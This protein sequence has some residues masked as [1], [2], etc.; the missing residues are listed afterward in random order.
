MPLT[1]DDVREIL[2][3]ID[4]SPVEEIRAET[5]RFTLYA[6]REGPGVVAVAPRPDGGTGPLIDIVD[7]TTRDGN[8]SLWSATGLTTADIVAVAPTID[9]VGF[10]AAD[11]SSSTHMAVAVRFHGEDPWERLRLVSQA[12]PDTPLSYITTGMRFISWVPCDEDL[13]RLSFRCVARNGIRRF[14]V[15]DP[16]NDPARLRRVARV[17]KEEGIE[18]VVIGLTYSVS[19]V[20]THTYYAER[21]AALAD[22]ADMDRLYLKDPGGLLTPDAVRELAP[23]FVAAAGHRVA[24]LH[25]HTTIGLAPIVYLEG[26][27]AGFQVLHTAVG[28]L[29]RGTSNPA[30]ETTVRDLV[31]SGFSHRLDLEA[32]GEM[33][34]HFR[35]L[36]SERDLPV[37]LPQEFDATYYHHQLAG[38]MVSTTKRML[39]EQHRAELVRNRPGGG[40]AGAGGD[41][42]PD[43]RHAGLADGRDPGAPERGRP[44]ALVERL[45]RDDPLLPRPLR[46]AVGAGRPGDRRPRA[47]ATGRRGAAPSRAD[48]AGGGTRP[49]RNADL[50]RRAAAAAD[51]ARGTGRRD[52]RGARRDRT[53]SEPG[54]QRLRAAAA[55]GRPPRAG[56]AHPRRDRRPRPGVEPCLTASRRSSSTST[57]RSCTGPG[58]AVH[59]QPGAREVLARIRASGRRLAIFTNGSHDSPAWFA[60]GLRAAGLDIAD[61]EMLTPLRSVQAYLRMRRLDG[62][63]LAFATE[64]ARRFLEEEGLLLAADEGP[65]DAV[66]VA[67]ADVVDFPLLE[68]AARA[69]IAGARL[70]TAS[71]APAYAGADG[72]ILS[73]GAMTTAAL[74]KASS[75]RP[76]IVGKPSRAAMRTV[77]EQ[78]GVRGGQ[79]AVIGDDLTMDVALGRLGGARTILV[80]SGISGRLALDAIPERRRPDAVVGGVAELLDWL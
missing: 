19:P 8:Q 1:E 4:E 43:H 38:G 64:P 32:L 21:A 65:V 23:H 37:G 5:G 2:R 79:L 61:E 29:A 15:A 6:L 59:V 47:L 45:R 49:L 72:P 60:A 68:R 18:E 41:G 54:R 30:A 39:E 48:P 52:G 46:R 7:T 77:E 24:E 42:I 74:A 13:M 78:V 11:F 51:D 57:G 12:M 70:L 62:P 17:A 27:R 67:H 76:V 58:D 35:R 34:D 9:R 36:A 56:A 22:C 14:Q 28:P 16:T 75:T 73:R 33:A 71:Y 63:V 55:G 44:G 10:H 31:A 20:H 40:R 69:I 3:L 66:F 25:S 50:G 80:A 53:S 26:A